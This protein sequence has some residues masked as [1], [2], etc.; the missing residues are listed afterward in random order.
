MAT[1]RDLARRGI[2]VNVIQPGFVD[3]EGNPAD[4]P[5]ASTFLPDDGDGAVRQA[6][7]DRRRRRLLASPQ[8]SYVTG[9][10][11]RVDVGYAA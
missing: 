11:L 6:G 8:A 4:G 7:G 2:T 1:A 5:A 10:V 3:T 9:S